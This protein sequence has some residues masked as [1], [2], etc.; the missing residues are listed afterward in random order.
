MR[1]VGSEEVRGMMGD[2][3]GRDEEGGEREGKEKSGRGG[4]M[5]RRGWGGGRV[6]LSFRVA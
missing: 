3:S 6:Y 1:R 5:G 2:G 4:K